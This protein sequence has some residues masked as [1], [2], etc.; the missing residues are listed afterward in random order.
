MLNPNFVELFDLTD[1]E[2]LTFYVPLHNVGYKMAINYSKNNFQQIRFKTDIVCIQCQETH[3]CLSLKINNKNLITAIQFDFCHLY[4]AYKDRGPT[5]HYAQVN[6]NA[7]H[8]N[9][10]KVDVV[11]D[12]E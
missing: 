1:P 5:K 12:P 10:Y 11:R 7:R 9:M 3:S 2:D 8:L 6:L 4:K